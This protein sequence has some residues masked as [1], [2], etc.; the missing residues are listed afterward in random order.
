MRA[1][2]WIFIALAARLWAGDAADSEAIRKVISTFSDRRERATVLAPDADISPLHRSYGLDVS[3]LYF[4]V[5]AIR[6][7]TPDVAFVDA[8][9]TQFGTLIMK[10]A[11]PAVFVLKRD[12]GS[13]KISVMRSSPRGY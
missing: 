13:W 12:A 8:S 4:E 9:A 6:F 7:V 10:H 11:R 2:C 3:Q 5:S 1:V